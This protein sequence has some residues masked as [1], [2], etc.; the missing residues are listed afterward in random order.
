LLSRYLMN[1]WGYLNETYRK[2]SVVATDDMIRFW[3]S[4][5][6]KQGHSRQ[7]NSRRRSGVELRRPVLSKH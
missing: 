4:E 5:V 3:K 1:A 7:R 2:Y 6:K